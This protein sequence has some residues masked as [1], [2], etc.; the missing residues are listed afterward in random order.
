MDYVN[1]SR[2]LAELFGKANQRWWKSSMW[3]IEWH[4]SIRNSAR[5]VK[6]RMKKWGPP[7]KAKY[8]LVTDSE[9][10]PWGKGE[11][12]PG[13]G[14]K[15][16]LKPYVYKQTKHVKVRCRTF[17][18]TVRRVIVYGKVKYLRYGAEAR[19]SLNRASKSYI[20]DPKPSDLSMV[21]MKLE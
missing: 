13:R 12:N 14:V 3:K 2:S 1:D 20:I 18:R 7:H 11:K 16:N 9:A 5:H 6:S 10:V 8:Y 4:G 15:E 21:R 19:A 17:C